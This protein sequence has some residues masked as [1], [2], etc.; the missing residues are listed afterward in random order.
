VSRRSPSSRALVLLLL[1]C[2]AG[3]GALPLPA[4]VY[5]LV[6]LG[7]VLLADAQHL[8]LRHVGTLSPAGPG[9]AADATGRIWGRLEPRRLAA[10]DPVGQAVVARVKLSHPPGAILVTSTGEAYVTHKSPTREGFVMSV[11]DTRQAAL[12]RELRGL[13]GLPVELVEAAGFVYAAAAG[14][15]RQDPME[16]HLYQIEMATGRH[17]EVLASADTAYGWGLAAAGGLLYLGHLPSPDNPRGGRVEVREAAT[18]SLL[19]SLEITGGPLRGLYAWQA[20]EAQQGQVL[21]FRDAQG[22]GTELLILDPL[23]RAEPRRSL[24]QSPVARVLGV[25]GDVLAYLDYPPEAQQA[26]M[27]LCFCDLGS[28]RELKRINVRDRLVLGGGS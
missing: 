28:G 13:A 27:N 21:L 15:L 18:F 11:V 20:A 12:L 9:V 16:W 22:G 19:G 7:R 23:L 2:G 5:P 8:E 26:K 17:R 1:L 4:G 6:F 10:L 3:L 25:H 14:V 24:L